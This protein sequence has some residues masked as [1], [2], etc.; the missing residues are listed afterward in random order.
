[1]RTLLALSVVGILLPG[2]ASGQ[3]SPE[4]TTPGVVASPR[5]EMQE[6]KAAAP[7]GSP[8]LQQ[9]PAAPRPVPTR[10]RRG[11]MVGYIEDA[12]IESKVR[13]RFDTASHDT[14]PD[15][16]EFFYAKCGCYS[17]LPANDPAFD[18]D[19]PGPRPGAANDVNFRQ[20]FLEGEFA[21]DPRVSIFGQIPIRWLLPQ[22][23]IP[24]TGGSFPN[25]T[26]FGD[27]RLGVKLG[28]VDSDVA[29]LTAKV[30][31]YLP[32]GDAAKGL[33]TDH[34]SVEPAVL[35]QQQLSNIVTLESEVGVWLPIG[36]AAPVPTHAD[37]K[38]AGTVLF[39]GIGPSFTVYETDRVQVA[40]VIELV[41]WRVRDGNQTSAE[42]SD[43]SGT[44]IVNL[45]IG[46]RA[47]F[48]QGSVYAG[49][50]HALTDQDWYDNI[51]RFEYRYSF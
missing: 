6:L 47:I 22:S 15:R 23:F 3:Q 39:Y 28:A 48:G 18:P 14:V 44:N 11:S 34:A 33:G 25:Q 42:G 10:R 5:V 8:L 16:A 21:V 45:K 4:G 35:Y 19:A 37:G 20:L 50:G 31:L 26:G 46:A 12:T 41:G 9:T 1:M 7:S 32:T 24:G 30:Q 29:A 17:G 49:Y 38:F 43:A 2:M 40:P 13:L 51:F 27:V 36:G